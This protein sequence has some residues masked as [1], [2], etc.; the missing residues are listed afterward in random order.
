MTSKQTHAKGQ[1]W[2]VSGPSGSGKTS[3][4]QNVLDSGLEVY[5]SVSYT[6]R[7]RRANEKEGV[8]YYFVSPNE[9]ED[10]RRKDLFLECA[11]VHSYWYGT[12]K[13][14]VFGALDAGRDVLLDIDVQGAGQVR[15]RVPE[16]LSIMIFPPCY[17]VLQERLRNRHSDSAEVIHK[18]MRIAKSELQHYPEYDYIL[19]NDHFETAAKEL[20]HIIRAGSCRTSCRTVMVEGILSEFDEGHGE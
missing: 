18:R 3:L 9:F 4:C 2:I 1:L 20:G 15:N 14:H 8:D 17:E 10:M 5:F 12:G 13:D 6:T 11:R 7:L 16:A 19:I